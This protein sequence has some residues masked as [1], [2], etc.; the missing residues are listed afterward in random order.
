MKSRTHVRSFI[1]GVCG[2]VLTLLPFSPVA[3]S[4]ELIMLE[5]DAC[6]WCER[7]HEEIG[8]VYEKTAE[9]KI[10]PLRIV[11]IHGSVPDDL[12]G[13]RIERFTPTFILV[14][15]G[16]EIDRLRG[17]TGDEFFW[18]L[19]GEMLDKLPEKPASDS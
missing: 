15:D 5:Q 14:E 9:G 12:K 16:K 13:I 2:M 7:W 1:A 6:P 3:L 19:L 17:Y 4:A 8:V 10:A 11:N 18:F